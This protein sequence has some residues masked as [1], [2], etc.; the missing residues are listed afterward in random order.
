ML[1]FGLGS[2]L[3]AIVAL[4]IAFAPEG[5]QTV[6]PGPLE[7]VFPI[8]NNSVI[9]QTSVEVDL[10]VGYEATIYIDNF[11][12]PTN[13]VSFSDGTNVYRWSPSLVS[14]VMSEWQPGEHTVRVEWVRITGAPLSGE[15]EWTFR[16]Q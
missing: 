15:F 10:E 5:E 7:A 8:P 11:A 16:V 9:R 3:V 6:L 4:G 14:A 12:I 2:L 1:Y 13:E